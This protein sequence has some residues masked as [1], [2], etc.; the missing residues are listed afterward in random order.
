MQANRHLRRQP[1]APPP[2]GARQPRPNH[3][4]VLGRQILAIKGTALKTF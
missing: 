1:Q 3:Y 2:Q 4:K